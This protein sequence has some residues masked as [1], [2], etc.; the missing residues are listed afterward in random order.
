MVVVMSIRT[1]LIMLLLHFFVDFTLQVS[2]GL[3]NLK[4]KRWWAQQVKDLENSI[5][6][7]DWKMGMFCHSL[8]WSILIC[9]PYFLSA[10][11]WVLLAVIALNTHIH[12]I[13]D[14]LKCNKFKINLGHDQA[15]HFI[16]ILVTWAILEIIT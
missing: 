1:L 12:A 11:E 5:Y 13:I 7:N 2:C 10:N 9:L 15:L 4:Q 14:D 8:W 16:Q 3:A 6:R